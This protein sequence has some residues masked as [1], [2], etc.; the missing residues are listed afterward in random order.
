MRQNLAAFTVRNVGVIPAEIT[1]QNE[2]VI[3]SVRN[4][5]F[6]KVRLETSAVKVNALP[7]LRCSVVVYQVFLQ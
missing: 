2:A 7:L 4:K 3:C 6:V 5:E 1:Q